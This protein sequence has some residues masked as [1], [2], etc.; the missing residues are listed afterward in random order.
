MIKTK[1]ISVLVS[2]LITVSGLAS[3]SLTPPLLTIDAQELDS[4]RTV[5]RTIE[6]THKNHG[7]PV[8][9]GYDI[10][11]SPLVISFSNGHVYAFNFQSSNP[12]WH[13]LPIAHQNVLYSFDDPEGMSKIPMN[14][15]YTLEG[16]NAFLYQIDLIDGPSYL[17]FLVMV[18]ERFHQFQFQSFKPGKHSGSYNAHLNA[19]NLALVQLEELVLT[20]F[21]K[22]TD[23]AT[24]VDRIKDFI[25]VRQQRFNL[26]NASSIDWEQDQQRMEG[27]AEYV[28]IKMFEDFPLLSDY[29]GPLHMQTMMEMYSNDDNIADRAIKHRH[30]GVGASMAFAL[31]FLKVKNWKNQTQQGTPLDT[32]LINFLK[33]SQLEIASRVDNVKSNYGFTGVFTA[34]NEKIKSYQGEIEGIMNEFNDQPEVALSLYKPRGMGMSGGGTN[35]QMFHLA[36]GGTLFVDNVSVNTTPDNS[37]KFSLVNMP[38]VIQKRTGEIEFKVEKDLEILINKQNVNLQRLLKSDGDYYFNT[39]SWKGKS[40]E[41]YSNQYP[42]KLTVRN[43]KI[44]IMFNVT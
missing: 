15:S 34:I 5:A 30:Y 37:W 31:D 42:G 11:Q 28:S 29:N 7:S 26:L 44:Y 6:A 13:V 36:D 18:H 25:A 43:N 4:I 3:A 2:L 38:V 9:E 24:K 14:P 19:Q 27:L 17:P 33:L 23:N 20:D 10:S 12:R 35:L 16:Q 39:I 32:L 21:L 1:L 22:A 8:W 40:C 41:F